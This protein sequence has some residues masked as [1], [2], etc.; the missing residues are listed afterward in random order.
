MCF[1]ALLSSCTEWFKFAYET[2]TVNQ[3]IKVTLF[4]SSNASNHMAEYDAVQ[5]GCEKKNADSDSVSSLSA[6][7]PQVNI[8]RGGRF[9]QL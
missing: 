2:I 7:I 4:P 8:S 6:L 5:Y 3:L 1:V 9:T